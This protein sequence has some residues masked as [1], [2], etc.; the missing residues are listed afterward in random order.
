M[1]TESEVRQILEGFNDPFL[2]KSLK[3]TNGVVEVKIKEE[4]TCER[5]TSDCQS[6]NK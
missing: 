1:K 4:K 3:E 5:K 2:H 6:G